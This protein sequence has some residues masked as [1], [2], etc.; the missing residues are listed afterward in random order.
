VNFSLQSILNQRPPDQEIW[1][2][3]YG[4][5]MWNPEISFDQSILATIQGF[6]RSFC[7][8]STEHRGTKEFPGLVLGLEPG[9]SC[10]GRALRIPPELKDTQLVQI[11]ER[12][13]I[14]EAYEP[15]WV[16]VESEIG[17]L[18]AIAFV[19]RLDHP[20]Y[21]CPTMQVEAKGKRILEAKG[22]RG[23]CVEYL[24]QTIQ[25]LRKAQIHDSRL[26]NLYQC[27]REIQSQQASQRSIGG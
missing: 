9:G 26:E 19:V 4:S 23:P 11:W 25:Y 17:S 27:V 6:H 12:E 7:L 10:I 2:F 8:W 13:M 21:V 14:T 15:Q 18:E 20:K 24:K 3:A 16:R 22:K 1:I 5:L